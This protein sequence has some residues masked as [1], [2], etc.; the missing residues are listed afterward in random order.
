MS[1]PNDIPA[2][3]VI[4]FRSSTGSTLTINLPKPLYFADLDLWLQKWI[5]EL[6]GWEAIEFYS[7][8]QEL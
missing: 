3:S 5:K 6:P 7:E 8:L 4:F 2:L 1:N